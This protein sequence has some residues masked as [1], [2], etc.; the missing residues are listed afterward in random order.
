MARQAEQDI[1]FVPSDELVEPEP[2]DSED[3]AVHVQEA[4]ELLGLV[5]VEVEA[6]DVTDLGQDVADEL[7]VEAA[8]AA[9][10]E[11]EAVEDEAEEEHE[12]DVEEILRRHY[13]IES[14]EP[15][16]EPTRRP[17]DAAEF[18][19]TSCYLRKPTSQVA[20]P[21]SGICVDCAANAS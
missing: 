17:S 19:C 4:D 9:A 21:E 7:E 15:E 8:D 12:D 3:A 2:V 18:V 10:A 6:I 13:G 14:T 5:T 16:V 1:E 11:A 20:D